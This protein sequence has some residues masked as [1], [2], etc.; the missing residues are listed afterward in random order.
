MLDSL[1]SLGTFATKLY[2]AGKA[3][4]EHR[5]NMRLYRDQMAQAQ[6]QFDAQMDQS[7]QRR[8]KD[9]QTAGIHPLFAMGASVGASPTLTASAGSAPRSRQG[10]SIEALAESL[11]MIQQNRARARR[12]EAEAMYFDSL[13]AKNRQ[14]FDS[15]GRDGVKTFPLGTKSAGDLAAKPV[16]TGIADEGGGFDYYRPEVPMSAKSGVRAGTAP[17][18]M[19][20]KMPDGRTIS[21][22][23]PD[24]GLDEIGQI[25]YLYQR[26]I[27]KGTD[28]MVAFSNAI[29]KAK[30]DTKAWHAQQRKKGITR[31]KRY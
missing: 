1:L 29:K 24:L 11:G 20:I 2:G 13:T 31:W 12:D 28:A 14:E 6:S 3:G 23:D 30:R 21:H 16:G 26:A 19:K 5:Q 25:N 15:R 9:A 27:H 22:Y 18:T 10:E 17:G 8:V 7:I 4:K